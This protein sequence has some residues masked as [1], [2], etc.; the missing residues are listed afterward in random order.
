M[1][2]GTRRG[3]PL[4]SREEGGMDISCGY[5]TASI[6]GDWGINI[7]LDLHFRCSTEEQLG[8]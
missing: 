5:L 2:D 6:L 8:S 4:T 3:P 7:F 1:E